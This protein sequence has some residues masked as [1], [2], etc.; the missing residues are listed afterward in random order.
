M[1]FGMSTLMFLGRRL[2]R[3]VIRGIAGAGVNRLEVFMQ[4]PHF[5]A[6][7][8]AQLREVME[9]LDAYGVE[10]LSAHAPI[11]RDRLKDREARRLGLLSLCASDKALRD[12]SVREL[13]QAIGAC[14]A[15]GAPNLV[16]HTGLVSG[17]DEEV[18]RCVESLHHAA[19]WAKGLGVN[20]AL[21]NGTAP[22]TS[23]GLLMEVLRRL[24]ME[25]AGI[26]L[27]V[28]HSAIYSNPH[29][30]VRQ[31]RPFLFSVHLHDN[32]GTEDQHLLPGR[33]TVDF[34][35]VVAFLRKSGFIGIMTMEVEPE[36]SGALADLFA[37]AG[38]VAVLIDTFDRGLLRA[39]ERGP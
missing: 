6:A 37:L 21:E 15:F 18:S 34:F 24:G 7:D 8:K 38:R 13:E 25:N 9:A 39:V 33:G 36:A 3:E 11:Y 10:V 23:V 22:G 17:D 1:K 27:D 16:V 5:D 20:L 14:A 32:D 31:A 19:E 35:D 4:R 12:Q 29:A 26:C 28:G 2:D 30:D